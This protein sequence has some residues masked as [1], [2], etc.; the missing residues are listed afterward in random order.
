MN[1]NKTDTEELMKSNHRYVELI[2]KQ[3]QNRGLTMEQL[4]EEGN[5]GLIYAAERFAYSKGLTFMGYA[6][7]VVRM[8][9]L[10]A[11]AAILQGA[12]IP[13][14]FVQRNRNRNNRNYSTP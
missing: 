3:Y 10:Q 11:L 12:P 6:S 7:W 4:I 1:K 13:K 5:K 9:I 14:K 2:A 8:S